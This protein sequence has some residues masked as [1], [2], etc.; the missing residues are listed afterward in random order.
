MDSINAFRPAIVTGE[1][2]T[3]MAHNPEDGFWLRLLAG[4]GVVLTFVGGAFAA[5]LGLRGKREETFLAALQEDN[6]SLRGELRELREDLQQASGEIAKLRDEVAQLR[7]LE[8]AYTTLEQSHKEALSRVTQAQAEI[9]ELQR[10]IT[11]QQVQKRFLL[12]QAEQRELQL[13]NLAGIKPLPVPVLA[14]T[15]ALSISAEGLITE[16]DAG[17]NELYGEQLV[18]KS[19]LSMIPARFYAKHLEGF[20]RALR[21]TEAP[22][23]PAEVPMQRADGSEMTVNLSVL[24]DGAGFRVTL[25]APEGKE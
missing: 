8:V 17:A 5:V 19:V 9:L 1:W 10:I 2:G 20:V 4:S 14:H 21:E 12:R 11:E 24:R 25:H 13:L 18:G 23:H 6:E 15:G 3:G 22:P 16:S 7:G